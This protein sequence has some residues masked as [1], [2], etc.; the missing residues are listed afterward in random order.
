[1]RRDKKQYSILVIEDNPGDFVIVEDLLTEQIFLPVIT[2]VINYKAA[3]DILASGSIFDIVLLDLSLPDKTGENLVKEILGVTK[4]CCPVIILTGYADIDFSMRSVALGISDYLLKD[5]LNAVMLYKSIIYAI[6]RKKSILELERSQKQFSDLFNL[7][8][9]PMWVF[10]SETFRFIKVNRATIMLYGYTE[11][12][13][14]DMNLMDIKRKEDIIKSASDIRKGDPDNEM[15]KSTNWHHKKSGE[16]IEVEIY[17]TPII[18]NNKSCRSV[19]AIDVTEK[20]QYENKITRAI[21]KTQEDERYEIGGELHDNVCQILAASQFSLAMLQKSIPEEKIGLLDKC[22]EHIKMALDE[23]RK[24]SH[25]L[26]PAFFDD[27]TLEEAFSR[28]FDS[29]NLDSRIQISFHFDHSV[30]QYQL[31]MEI[32]LNLYRILQEQL[33]NILK[34]AQADTIE[35]NVLV[36][37]HKLKMQIT[38]NGIGFDLSTAKKGIGLANMK[39]RTE[40]FSGKFEIHTS[41]GNGCSVILDIPLAKTNLLDIKNEDGAQVQNESIGSY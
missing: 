18:I 40:L 11:A 5:D 20:N 36:Y 33:R 22:K 19:I 30:K 39:R 4:S 26:A 14:L 2:H 9:Q 10:E 34:Y 12:E 1:M 27:S 6:E 24:L 21:I 7:S 29:F 37:N 23:I 13:F 3:F 25:R 31:S 38:D 28:L 17:S 8:P 35:V 41:P 32:Q 16:I 15:Y